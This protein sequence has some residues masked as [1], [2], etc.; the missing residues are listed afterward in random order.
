M[1]WL[2]LVNN[3]EIQRYF[4]RFVVVLVNILLFD[5]YEDL[6]GMYIFLSLYKIGR[7]VDMISER[8]IIKNYFK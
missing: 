1:K 3:E 7:I 8:I 4:F 6:E 5:L 2:F